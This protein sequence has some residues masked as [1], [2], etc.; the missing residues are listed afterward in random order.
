MTW[1]PMLLLILLFGLLGLGRTLRGHRPDY[2]DV[3]VG[4]RVAM[5]AAYFGLAALLTLGMHV[6]DRPLEGLARP[7][8][9]LHHEAPSA[10][11]S[12]SSSS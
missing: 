2:Y 10:R 6:A 5:G 8:A 7:E 12:Q 9:G 4:R 3:P 1:H 11:P